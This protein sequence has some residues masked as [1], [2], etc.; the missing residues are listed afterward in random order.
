MWQNPTK[1][2]T[3]NAK[4]KADWIN[5]VRK[6][7]S[8]LDRDQLRVNASGMSKDKT[9]CVAKEMAEAYKTS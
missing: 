8:N 1:E 2:L 3:G 9:M 6:L 7:Q 4:A 5:K